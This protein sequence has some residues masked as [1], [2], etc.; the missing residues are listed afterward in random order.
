VLLIATIGGAAGVF[1]VVV[2]TLFL[3]QAETVLPDLTHLFGAP[4]L[5]GAPLPLPRAVAYHA[6][7]AGANA[8]PS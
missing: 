3:F 6:R 8:C 4:G 2:G 1:R 7:I 5:Q